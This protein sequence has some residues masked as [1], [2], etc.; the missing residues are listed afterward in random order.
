MKISIVIPVYNDWEYLYKCIESILLIKHPVSEII[1]VDDGSSIPIPADLMNCFIKNHCILLHLPHK[2]KSV[3]RNNGYH[4]ASSDIVLFTDAD[5]Y[6]HLNSVENLI[7]SIDLNKNDNAFQL[8]IKSFTS[9]PV[10]LS[11]DIFQSSVQEAKTLKDGHIIWL[12]PAGFAVRK[13]SINIIGVDIFDPMALR[14]GDTLLLAH[15]LANNISPRFVPDAIVYH[16]PSLSIRKYIVKSFFS[17]FNE[18]YAYRQ[19]VMKNIN[20]KIG[21]SN[22]IDIFLNVIRLSFNPTVQ[23]SVSVSVIFIILSRKLAQF[24]GKSFSIPCNLYLKFK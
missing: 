15:L 5:C 22:K 1:I 18:F 24:L 2:G 8:K 13:N 14:A 11:E 12:N 20:Q 9:T 23:F 6:L 17:S 4:K 10:G 16:N 3:A 7:K 21:I 19:S